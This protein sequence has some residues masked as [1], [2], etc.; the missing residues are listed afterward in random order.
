MRCSNWLDQA[1]NAF[2]S[3]SLYN[4]TENEAL[5]TFNEV[6]LSHSDINYTGANI[7]GEMIYIEQVDNVEPYVVI[8]NEDEK[9]REAAKPPQVLDDCTKIS[10]CVNDQLYSFMT[11]EALVQNRRPIFDL[12]AYDNGK[13]AFEVASSLK[14]GEERAVKPDD[15]VGPG[16]GSI[17]DSTL[18]GPIITPE[19]AEELDEIVAAF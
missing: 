7:V 12:S 4:L 17:D 19:E 15:T 5:L 3:D 6:H 14:P 1:L 11:A 2:R 9:C 18:L 16:L 10:E 8:C 13:G